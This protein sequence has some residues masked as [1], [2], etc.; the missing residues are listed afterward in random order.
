DP[1]RRRRLRRWRQRRG[2][3]RRQ[4]QRQ[5][6]RGARRRR[7][8]Q[9]SAA[10]P[11]RGPGGRRQEQRRTARLGLRRPGVTGMDGRALHELA[12]EVALQLPV[13]ELTHP[14]GPEWDVYKVVGKI[15]MLSSRLPDQGATDVDEHG[16]TRI[17]ELTADPSD[18]TAIKSAR[19]KRTPGEN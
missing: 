4:L 11:R 12:D 2:D 15:F 6:R 10:H 8:P 7:P 17:I 16:G 9:G 5:D 18:D 14:F 1:P 3:P 13:S 19:P